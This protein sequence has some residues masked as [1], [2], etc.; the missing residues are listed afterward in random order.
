[1]P[2]SLTRD[3][4]NRAASGY[5]SNKPANLTTVARG[6]T[7]LT[8]VF[9]S[10]TDGPQQLDYYI[11]AYNANGVRVTGWVGPLAVKVRADTAP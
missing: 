8:W 5:I 3:S 6:G 4:L 11:E 7:V 10:R 9:G 2:D 1:M